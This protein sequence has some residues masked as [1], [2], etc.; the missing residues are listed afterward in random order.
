M[1]KMKTHEIL[2]YSI[3]IVTLIIALYSLRQSNTVANTVQPEQAHHHHH[4]EV[5]DS[6]IP[7]ELKST[8][9]R[10]NALPH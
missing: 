10:R 2:N 4:S 5:P 6:Q 8:Q 3:M 9:Q 7:A 1:S